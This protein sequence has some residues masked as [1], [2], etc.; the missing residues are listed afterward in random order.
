MTGAMA[1]VALAAVAACGS[2]PDPEAE[3]SEPT[4]VRLSSAP[5][6]TLPD[7]RDVT[8]FTL[9]S[10]AGTEVVVIDYG[11]II[12]HLR[13]PDRNDEPGD[14]ALGFDTLEGYLGESPYFGA[15]VGRYGN[16]IAGGRF[17]LDGVSYQL[18]TNNGPNHL[19]GGA[20]GFDKVMWRAEPFERNAMAEGGPAAGVRLT[21]LS[22]DGEEGYPGNLTTAVTYTLGENGALVVDYELSTDAPTPANITQH[23]YF[24][25]AGE[26]DVLG[27]E[28]RLNADRFTPVD[29]TM[30]PTGEI[31]AVADTPFDFTVSKTI[32]NDIGADHAQLKAGGGFDHNFIINRDAAADAVDRGLVLAARAHDP[33]SGRV[34]EVYTTEPAVQFYSGNFLD[35]SITGKGGAA[36]GHRAGFCL[37]TQRYPDSPNQPSFP[38]TIV[39]PGENYHSRTVFRFATE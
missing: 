38:S 4:P 32:G 22:A 20:I 8:A 35:G 16:R 33:G 10:A 30:I 9:R 19:H 1:W 2:S 34:L 24:N 37:E 3:M 31:V 15:I 21:Y 27:H 36:Y 7:G 12:T 13:V 18:A 29:A 26:G 23:T 17:E 25:L 28:L 6:G 11:A 14:V 39:R 5:F